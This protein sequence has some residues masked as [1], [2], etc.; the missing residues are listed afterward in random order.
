MKNKQILSIV[1]VLFCIALISA[2]ADR[3]AATIKVK[4]ILMMNDYTSRISKF[5]DYKPYLPNLVD[6]VIIYRLATARNYHSEAYRYAK[7]IPKYA[8]KYN[9]DPQF[10]ARV[11]FAETELRNGL[12]SSYNAVGLWQIVTSQ[13]SEVLYKIRDGGLIPT[14]QLGEAKCRFTYAENR[15]YHNLMFLKS[16]RRW[17]TQEENERFI[18]LGIRADNF[19]KLYESFFWDPEVACESFCYIMK[20]VKMPIFDGTPEYSV[21]A[22]YN[23]ENSREFKRLVS[24]DYIKE[25]YMM[26]VFDTKTFIYWMKVNFNVDLSAPPTK[27]EKE[28]FYKSI[29]QEVTLN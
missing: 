11:G 2:V 18:D 19:M 27:E 12:R 25:R 22:Y 9:L 5:S 15:E 3:N 24:S 23:G 21:I 29:D 17:L 26:I 8:R 28:Y 14:L 4:S 1:L 20:Y 7:N 16:Q 13:H 6:F 10:I